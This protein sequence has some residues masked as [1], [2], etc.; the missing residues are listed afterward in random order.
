M[1]RSFWFL[2]SL[3]LIGLIAAE[4]AAGQE[5]S[6][7]DMTTI[8]RERAPGVPMAPNV[9]DVQRDEPAAEHAEVRRERER[10]ARDRRGP[11]QPNR[12]LPMPR[13]VP[14]IIAP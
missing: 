5:Q 12:E 4:A 13:G 9:G 1:R 10:V 2:M 6:S 3:V 11:A 8:Q 14:S 7:P